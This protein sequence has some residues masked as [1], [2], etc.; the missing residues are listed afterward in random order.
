M[1]LK[2]SGLVCPES[3]L[4]SGTHR[5]L[6][7]ATCAP[8]LQNHL[9]RYA[10]VRRN[11]AV[12]QVHGLSRGFHLQMLRL[13]GAPQTQSFHLDVAARWVA[14]VQELEVQLFVGQRVSLPATTAAAARQRGPSPSRDGRE[15]SG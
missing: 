12:D 6:K 14:Q 7:K 3:F 9:T 2:T 10:L 8:S 5:C 4:A 1:T 13:L 15:S 11:A